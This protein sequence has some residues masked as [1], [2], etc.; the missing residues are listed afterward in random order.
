MLILVSSNTTKKDIQ[1]EVDIFEKDSFLTA[2]PKLRLKAT[3]GLSRDE[4]D[5]DLERLQVLLDFKQTDAIPQ[6]VQL[7]KQTAQ[8]VKS[9]G[10]KVIKLF[11]FA[12]GVAQHIKQTRELWDPI[13]KLFQERH[14]VDQDVDF[15]MIQIWDQ[16]QKNTDFRESQST[17]L[18]ILL[19]N[20]KNIDI[21]GIDTT[22]KRLGQAVGEFDFEATSTSLQQ[23]QDK[24]G[25]LDTLL[26]ML[27]KLTEMSAHMDALVT[28]APEAQRV[29]DLNARLANMEKDQQFNRAD[30]QSLQT[31]RKEM[32]AEMK[33]LVKTR[34]ELEALKTTMDKQ[35]AQARATSLLGTVKIPELKSLEPQ[36]F[37]T[38]RALFETHA[39][40]QQWSDKVANQALTLACPDSKVFLPLK[41]ATP[42]WQN[43]PT[44]EVL[45][46]WEKR[47]CPDSHRDLAQQQMTQL[48][49]GI[50]EDTQS[51]IDRAVELYIRAQFED[52]DPEVDEGFVN[53]L[54]AT[55]RDGRLR[56]PLRRKK[57]KT[58]SQ[59]REAVNEESAIIAEDPTMAHQVTAITPSINK[60]SGVDGM[61]SNQ[62]PTVTCSFCTG[63]HNMTNCFK[64]KALSK[65]SMQELVRA[66][67]SLNLQ[68]PQQNDSQNYRGKKRGRRGGRGGG[69]GRG[70]DRGG[71]RG[72]GF[73]R[74]NQDYSDS[75]QPK[76]AK[77]E[78]QKN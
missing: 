33:K 5:V 41:L 22:V 37:R 56:A 58:I 53:R 48:H 78:D 23:V 50:D 60:M 6:R 14:L 59:L 17:D 13:L 74:E 24:V 70:N 76:I 65:L 8:L 31:F 49:Q 26:P 73:K 67:P 69:R 54:I 29:L 19:A 42:N 68:M 52:K 12:Q 18:Q 75:P 10:N 39:N 66:N 35:P 45:D 20:T 28:L 44:K 4:F 2:G 51:Y 25:Q 63:S 64:A 71:N 32:D 30:L 1:D 46:S 15:N 72:R 7:L 61:N 36:V 21:P 40:L 55:F 77:I 27:P 16:L 9:N 62:K 3:R 43:M 11:G 34:E 57:P 38:W 47:C